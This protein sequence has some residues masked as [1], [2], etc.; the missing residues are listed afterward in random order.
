MWNVQILSQY[1]PDW[2]LMTRYW[3]GITLLAFFVCIL[4]SM[5]QRALFMCGLW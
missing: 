1:Q 2:T 4:A 5:S 3:E